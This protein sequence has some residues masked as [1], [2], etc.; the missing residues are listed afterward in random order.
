MKPVLRRRLFFS[1][2]LVVGLLCRLVHLG[3]GQPG[4]TVLFHRPRLFPTLPTLPILPPAATASSASADPAAG[5]PHVPVPPPSLPPRG[6]GGGVA[7]QSTLPLG[8]GGGGTASSNGSPTASAGRPRTDP[9]AQDQA[10]ARS[11]PAPFLAQ[12]D[13]AHGTEAR[14]RQTMLVFRLGRA[15]LVEFVVFQV[16]PDCRPIGRFRVAGHRGIEP[17]ALPWARRGRR[18]LDPGTYRLRART[19]PRGRAVVDTRVRRRRCA[20]SDRLIASC[21]RRRC[22]RLEAGF[23][24]SRRSR[25]ESLRPREFGRRRQQS[26]ARIQGQ[27]ADGSLP[28]RMASSAPGSRRMPSAPSRPFR[29]VL[30]VLLGMA[31]GLLGGRR[32]AIADGA[33]PASRHDPRASPGRVALAGTAC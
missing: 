16:A 19:L 8:G 14:C 28:V 5:A 3:W 4:P 10:R 17:G 13:L 24:G 6:G 1:A 29:P 9:T 15:A 11:P 22:L 20:R 12:L 18:M 23:A 25:S 7:S 26:P 33:D 21:P 31:I 32:A 27:D 30:F 2:L